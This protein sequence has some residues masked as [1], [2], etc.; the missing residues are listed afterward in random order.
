[1]QGTAT[2]DELRSWADVAQ[3]RF[4]AD[5]VLVTALPPNSPLPD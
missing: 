1:V 5:R 2:Y 4:G 3:K